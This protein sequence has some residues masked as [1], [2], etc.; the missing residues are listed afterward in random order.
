LRT[1]SAIFIGIWRGL[2]LGVVEVHRHHA[3]EL[4][5]LVLDEVVLGDAHVAPQDLALGR[6]L[7]GGEP[8]RRFAGVGPLG[9]QLGGGLAGHRPVQ[10]VLHGLEERLVVSACLS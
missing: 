2:I 7:P 4:L 9:D 5:D 3:L 10:L 6:V 1:Q 8:H